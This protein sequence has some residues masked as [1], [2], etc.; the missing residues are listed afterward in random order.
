M[1]VITGLTDF[2]YNTTIGDGTIIRL[3][4]LLFEK[5]FF[6]DVKGVHDLLLKNEMLLPFLQRVLSSWTIDP[7]L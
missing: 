7:P 6:D 3:D 1:G 5:F 4:F 2:V